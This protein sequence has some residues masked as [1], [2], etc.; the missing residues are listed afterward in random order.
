MD[1]NDLSLVSPYNSIFAS[2]SVNACLASLEAKLRLEHASVFISLI[3]MLVSPKKLS[4]CKIFEELLVNVDDSI[5]KI[6]EDLLMVDGGDIIGS[7]KLVV[8][9]TM[10]CGITDGMG[11]PL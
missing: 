3:S 6:F 5:C 9:I 8:V 11:N 1:L 4:I 10:F 7:V 2:S